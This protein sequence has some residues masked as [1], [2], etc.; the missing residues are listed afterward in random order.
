M[1]DRGVP[2]IAGD[3]FQRHAL[4]GEV[5]AVGCVGQFQPSALIQF[6]RERVPA[7]AMH[8]AVKQARAGELITKKRAME[9]VRKHTPA[10]SDDQPSAAKPD[11]WYHLQSSIRTL[12]DQVDQLTTGI[13]PA[14]IDALADELLQLAVQLRAATRTAA[15]TPPNPKP[16]PKR[17]TVRS[18]A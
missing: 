10:C 4:R 11:A 18:A 7:K 6:T 12:V 14:E 1:A 2:L 3:R 17:R 5:R 8:E 13:D 15:Q 16:K 9:I